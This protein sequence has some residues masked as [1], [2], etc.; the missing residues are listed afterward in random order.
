M[1]LET[2][3]LKVSVTLSKVCTDALEL[4]G[5][6]DEVKNEEAV[7]WYVCIV[8]GLEAS[9]AAGV[10]ALVILALYILLAVI[11]QDRTIL[12][13]SVKTTLQVKTGAGVA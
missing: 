11:E 9:L 12:L 8:F 7:I 2:R 3:S 5:P 4:E 1:S 13:A 6:P 10:F